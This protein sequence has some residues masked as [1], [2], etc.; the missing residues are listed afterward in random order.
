MKNL[1]IKLLFE[2]RFYCKKEL[3]KI[4]GFSVRTI[5]S[6]IKRKELNYSKFGRSVR[7]NGNY[8]N[9]KFCN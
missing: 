6:M 8:L 3:A 4:L 7:F 9:T 2:E 1:N 5:D